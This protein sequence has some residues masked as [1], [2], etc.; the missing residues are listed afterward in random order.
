MCVTDHQKV[1]PAGSSPCTQS[2]SS[3]FHAKSECFL[4]ILPHLSSGFVPNR[5]LHMC[6]YTEQM[7]LQPLKY[8]LHLKV[9][10]FTTRLSF[11]HIHILTHT[12]TPAV[13][14]GGVTEHLT[15][16]IATHDFF[17]L[18]LNI[19][20]LS[21]L[22]TLSTCCRV[23]LCLSVRRLKRAILLRP[24]P[25]SLGKSAGSLGGVPRPL[26]WETP[27]TED[28]PLLDGVLVEPV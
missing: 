8:R 3:P 22:L 23:C 1:S 11:T 13:V 19:P 6:T 17:F 20:A 7:N 12:N 16:K 21:T 5:S 10:P 26:V 15:A 18:C 14:R 4:V 2:C 9:Q 25:F 24:I 28:K 27:S